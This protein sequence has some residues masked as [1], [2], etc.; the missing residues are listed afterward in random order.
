MYVLEGCG[1]SH[2]AQ[3]RRYGYVNSAL[4]FCYSRIYL[5]L[6]SPRLFKLSDDKSLIGQAITDM[7]GARAVYETASRKGV[8]K[9]RVLTCRRQLVIGQLLLVHKR[10]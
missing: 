9:L 3:S 6:R 8:I 2:C 10:I 5:P 1:G 7:C 4:L